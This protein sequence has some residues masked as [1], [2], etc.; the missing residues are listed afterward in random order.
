MYINNKKFVHT[1]YD[2]LSTHT[3]HIIIARVCTVCKSDLP[4]SLKHILHTQLHAGASSEMYDS[5]REGG[6]GL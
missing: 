5:R 2:F 3:M 4:L 6:G 1:V